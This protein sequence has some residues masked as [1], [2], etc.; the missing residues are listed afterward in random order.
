MKEGNTKL[1]LNDKS[2]DFLNGKLTMLA[3]ILRA[4]R[5]HE[6]AERVENIRNTIQQQFHPVE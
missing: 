5:K 4:T 2:I 1:V 3:Q 6:E